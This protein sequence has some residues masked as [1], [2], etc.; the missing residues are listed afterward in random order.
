LLLAS[1]L[2]AKTYKQYK[3][4]KEQRELARQACDYVAG[5][6]KTAITAGAYAASSPTY[7]LAFGNS[8]ANYTYTFVLRD[9]YPHAYD[10]DIWGNAL[11]RFDIAHNRALGPPIVGDLL[12]QGT[13]LNGEIAAKAGDLLHPRRAASLV[14]QFGLEKIYLLKTDGN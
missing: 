12:L 1:A 11:S 14:A 6:E 2:Q 4:L 3:I 8:C 13:A 7:A 9:L 5:R 10:Y